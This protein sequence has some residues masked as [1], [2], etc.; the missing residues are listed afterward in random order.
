MTGLAPEV[1]TVNWLEPSR[2]LTPLTMVLTMKPL[3]SALATARV[4]EGFAAESEGVEPAKVSD[5]PNTSGR[6]VPLTP[7][8]SL[9]GR[10]VVLIRASTLVALNARPLPA[11]P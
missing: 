9:T 8:A 5:E 2:V 7:I 6:V 10:P 11:R 4:I 1:L 3:A